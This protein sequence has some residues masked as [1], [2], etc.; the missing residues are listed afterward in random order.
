MIDYMQ[1]LAINFGLLGPEI[2]LLAAACVVMLTAATKAARLIAPATTLVALAVAI[3]IAALQW[4]TTGSGFG[5]MVTLDRF[6]VLLRV[7]FGAG[8]LMAVLV[9]FRY[10]TA[11]WLEKPEYYAL[12][13]V[14]TLGMMVMTATTDLVII[15]LGLEIMSVPLYVMAA[16]NRRS[17]ESNESGIKYF[18]MGSFATAFLLMGIA[19]VFGAAETTNLK[20]ILANLN[21]ILSQRGLYLTTGAALLLVGFGFKVGAVPFHAWIPDVYQGA[22]TPV[23]AFFS[24]GPKAAGIAALLRI[25][26]FGMPD[27]AELE[28][29]FWVLAA[30][31]MTVGNVIALRQENVK[32]LLAY[33]SIAHAG[34]MLVALAVGGPAATSSAI[35]YLIGYALFNTGAFAVL[36]ALEA[37]TSRRSDFSELAGLAKESPAL[38]LAMAVFM[39]ALSGFPPTIGF[40][41]KYYIFS[42]AVSEGFIWLT[43]VGVLNSF[44]SV[45]YYLRVIKTIYFD[46]AS[47]PAPVSL[48]PGLAFVLL[49]TAVGTVGLGLFPQQLLELSQRA[50]FAL[51]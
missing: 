36:I 33:S 35:F 44:V 38:A 9:G 1:S 17:L 40:F 31:T 26:Q 27:L 3:A 2:V 18:I 51:L 11:H 15:F 12:L 19:L 39:F 20:T 21:Y 50:L 28:L 42:A 46:S 10:L 16:L 14:S 6:A 8:S 45:F 5:G 22:P 24:V 49:A 32:R 23:T 47:S 37:N 41:G 48:T 7:L 30:I 25:F 34:Y 29:I 13:L 43:V 4:N